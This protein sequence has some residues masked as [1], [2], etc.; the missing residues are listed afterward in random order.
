MAEKFANLGEH[1]RDAVDPAVAA[2][3]HAKNLKRTRRKDASSEPPLPPSEPS[4]PPL[5]V[6]TEP[7]AA[8]VADLRAAFD[9]V[10]LFFYNALEP[11][12]IG[13][14]W[15]PTADQKRPFAAMRCAHSQPSNGTSA[16]HLKPNKAQILHDCA[17]L[18]AHLV[19][20]VDAHS[21]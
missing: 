2:A 17:K 7:V 9:D 4:A 3:A 12:Q 6:G 10:A 19:Q 14:V 15:R 18:G 11:E 16:S 5:L 1:R 13:L 8:L 21:T 20:S